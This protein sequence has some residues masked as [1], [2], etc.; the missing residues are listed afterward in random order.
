M[1][2]RER[3]RE[4]ECEEENVRECGRENEKYRL[5]IYG[6]TDIKIHT[7]YRQTETNLFFY[8]NHLVP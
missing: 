4:R 7:V 1:R 6:R 2:G 5:W 3:E 8:N